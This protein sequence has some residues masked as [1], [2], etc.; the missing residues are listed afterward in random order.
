MA[1]ILVI[2]DDDAIRD[3]LREALQLDNLTVVTAPNG[4]IGMESIR[5]SPVDIVITDMEMPE[6]NGFEVITELR[7][8]FSDVKIIA[9]SGSF[10]FA[11]HADVLE[12]AKRLGANICLRKP[13]S[14]S[15]VLAA[16]KEVSQT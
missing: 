6:R 4:K 1:T 15:D 7:R 10:T 5:Q 8:D 9:M 14:I 11:N 12:E 16:V 13:F 2:D 3:L